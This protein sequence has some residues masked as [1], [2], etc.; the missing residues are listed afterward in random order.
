MVSVLSDYD[1]R[2]SVLVLRDLRCEESLGFSTLDLCVSARLD[3]A[4]KIPFDI[5]SSVKKSVSI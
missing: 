2:S 1:E 3:C 4:G 5:S